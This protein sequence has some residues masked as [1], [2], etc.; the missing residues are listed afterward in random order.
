MAH[1]KEVKTTKM[2]AAKTT[3]IT[4]LEYGGLQGAIDHF[5]KEL[6]ESKLPDLF[7]V[8]QRRANSSGHYAPARYSARVGKDG[9]DE[10]SLN[11]DDF[12][13]KTDEQVCQTL[14]HELVHHWQEHF[15]VQKPKQYSYHNKEW[16][17]KMKAIGLQPSSTG[18]VG[19]NETGQRMSDYVI[20]GGPF[21]QS[22]AR[23]AESG[24]KLNLESAHRPGKM[25]G[26]SD[27]KTPFSCPTCAAK[28][29]GKPATDVYCGVCAGEIFI[30]AGVPAQLMKALEAARMRSADNEGAK[31]ELAE[32]V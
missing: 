10:L 26:P 21:T 4:P 3:A 19:G 31:V 15:G 32:A 25:K 7:L 29:W 8:Y 1:R 2:K 9:K 18:M 24:W 20:R 6:F 11:P 23:L 22:F 16:A 12:I 13:S 27:S 14:V 17:A 30:R 5:N 28:I